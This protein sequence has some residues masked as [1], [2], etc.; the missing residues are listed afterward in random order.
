MITAVE[1]PGDPRVPP[2]RGL[3]GKN[4]PGGRTSSREALDKIIR[5]EVEHTSTGLHRLDRHR[6]R[7]EW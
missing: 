6:V 4:P 7:P 2:L 3:E 1:Q 5:R